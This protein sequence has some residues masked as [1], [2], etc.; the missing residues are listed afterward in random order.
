MGEI[1]EGGS[2]MRRRNRKALFAVLSWAAFFV[3]GY[4]LYVVVGAIF[5]GGAG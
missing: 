1:K 2:W 3:V 5:A 4:L